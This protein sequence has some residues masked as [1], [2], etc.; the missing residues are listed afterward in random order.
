MAT[1]AV[2]QGKG[3][4]NNPVNGDQWINPDGTINATYVI[5]HWQ[6]G[7]YPSNPQPYAVT[8]G[9][10]R[11]TN[12]FASGVPGVP[13]APV[14]VQSAQ[15]SSTG[16]APIVQSTNAAQQTQVATTAGTTQSTSAT[17]PSF[18]LSGSNLWIIGAAVAALVLMMGMGSSR[19][20]GR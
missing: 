5:D 3:T 14:E 16:N 7:G 8:V 1:S 6:S 17:T 4:P 13:V 19:Q 18:S 15:A 20:H 9:V 10:N 2:F 12:M 11:T